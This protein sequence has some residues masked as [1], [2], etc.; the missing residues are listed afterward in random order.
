M[1]VTAYDMIKA[2]VERSSSRNDGISV[3]YHLRKEGVEISARMTIYE[4][5]HI[6]AWFELEQAKADV[7]L[8]QER[9]LL[10]AL[11]AAE[12]EDAGS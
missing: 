12:V 2:A 10:Q 5:R 8:L 7:L 9:R 11:F 6:V 1:S 4:D 3:A